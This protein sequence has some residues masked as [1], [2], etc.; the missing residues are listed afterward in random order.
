[1]CETELKLEEL[2]FCFST[3]AFSCSDAPDHLTTPSPSVD[4][5]L[6]AGMTFHVMI[7]MWL[8]GGG[9]SISETVLVT[10]D[11]VECLTRLPRGL[12]CR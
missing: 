4:R 11:G 2:Q 10:Q 8:D 9:Y 12:L 7:G 6:E 1:M 5:G 3:G